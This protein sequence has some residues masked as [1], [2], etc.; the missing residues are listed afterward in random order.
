M[1]SVFS[2]FPEVRGFRGDFRL[3]GSFEP[4]VHSREAAVRLIAGH[5]QKF[6]FPGTDR[7]GLRGDLCL[8]GV[9]AIT[10]FPGVIRCFRR[11][12]R[13][14]LLSP[15][16]GPIE[17]GFS[18]SIFFRSASRIIFFISSWQAR[19]HGV[20]PHWPL[21]FSKSS[22]DAGAGACGPV[23]GERLIADKALNL[24]S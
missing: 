14:H 12:D 16:I 2:P 18:F 24:F 23:S 7:A 8:D 3:P 17:D 19:H 4:V 13:R 1:L 9:P 21:Q 15:F 20:V 10:A 5:I 6:A 22:S 11:T